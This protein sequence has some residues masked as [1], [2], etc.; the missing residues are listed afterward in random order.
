M[1]QLA[2]PLSKLEQPVVLDAIRVL[3]VDDDQDALDLIA[4][5][6]EDQAQ[7]EL[8]GCVHPMRALACA[9]EFRPDVFLVDVRMDACHGL[10]LVKHLRESEEFAGAPVIM[11]SSVDS[12]QEKA[13]CF[14]EGVSDYLVKFPDAVELHARVRYH[15]E[16]S[17][18]QQALEALQRTLMQQKQILESDLRFAAEVQHEMLAKPP[19]PDHLSAAVWIQP[20]GLVSGDYY[21]F[22]ERP[23]GGQEVFLGDATGHG[24][25]SAFITVMASMGIAHIGKSVSP[26]EV[27]RRLDAVLKPA[28]P[29]GH[30]MTGMALQ[31]DT[32]GALTMSAGGHPPLVVAPADGGALVILRSKNLPLGILNTAN[33]FDE[34]GYRLARGDK[35]FMYTDGIL[36]WENRGGEHFGEERLHEFLAAQRELAVGELVASLREALG[37]F[38][39]GVE[40]GD[41]VTLIAIEFHG[42]Q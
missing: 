24:I 20:C 12:A 21:H 34:Y 2:A 42:A 11:L 27:L 10:G 32:R 30:F 39:G 26:C 31:I 23:G 40:N 9:R 29:G 41:D 15:A 18:R 8:M 19:C 28:I 13:R 16:A 22:G 17:R 6:F 37:G 1:N 35:V 7:I 3:H 4:D 36:E 38:C 5:L 25:A 33:H 14:A